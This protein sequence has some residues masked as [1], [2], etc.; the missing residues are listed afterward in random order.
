M[1][2]GAQFRQIE[3]RQNYTIQRCKLI[4]KEIFFGDACLA[5]EGF[6]PK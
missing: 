1:P 4:L 3:K 2:H 5:F 6:C